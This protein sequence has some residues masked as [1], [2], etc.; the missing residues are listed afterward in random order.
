MSGKVI[1]VGDYANKSDDVESIELKNGDI[2][3]F[4]VVYPMPEDELKIIEL[5]QQG[6]DEKLFRNKEEVTDADFDNLDASDKVKLIRFG[7]TYSAMLISS[8]ICH[9]QIDENGNEAEE[10][11]EKP[12]KVWKD[13]DDVLQNCKKNLFHALKDFLQESGVA[14]V[15]TEGEAKK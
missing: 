9:V 13:A 7:Y 15:I 6:V 12:R 8:C 11:T 4:R 10:Q 14:K 2:V 5:V 3:K 1:Y